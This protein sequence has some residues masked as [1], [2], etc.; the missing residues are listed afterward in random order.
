MS[1]LSYII[2][3]CLLMGLAGFVSWF[4]YGTPFLKTLAYWVLGVCAILLTLQA[5]GLLD[6]LKGMMIPHV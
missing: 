1:V 3:M 5:F 6:E 4:P 2:F